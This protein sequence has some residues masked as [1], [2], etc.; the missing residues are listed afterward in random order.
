MEVIWGA[1]LC[2]M[3]LCHCF[4]FDH[5]LL[6]FH[7]LLYVHTGCNIAS[8]IIYKYRGWASGRNPPLDQLWL[9]VL[10]FMFGKENGAGWWTL[11]KHRMRQHVGHMSITDTISLVK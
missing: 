11:Q 8:T 5:H 6:Y 3:V 4:L 7:A 1:P 10:Q 9:H 2:F